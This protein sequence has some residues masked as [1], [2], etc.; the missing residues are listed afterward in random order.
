MPANLSKP[1]RDG[2]VFMGNISRTTGILLRRFQQ[3]RDIRR[4]GVRT[5][6][7]AFEVFRAKVGKSVQLPINHD[8]R[9]Q[10]IRMVRRWI[11]AIACVPGD[12]IANCFVDT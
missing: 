1:T 6:T 12:E 7:M 3:M 9:V 10:L 2:D 11:R 5:V 4:K 8:K